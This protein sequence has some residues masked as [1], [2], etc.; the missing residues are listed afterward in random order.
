MNIQQLSD[1]DLFEI[2]DRLP[3]KEFLAFAKSSLRIQSAASIYF[4]RLSPNY[5]ITLKLHPFTIIRVYSIPIWQ[6]KLIDCFGSS[7]Q[8]E[9]DQDPDTI[10]MEW[11]YRRLEYGHMDRSAEIVNLVYDPVV[12]MRYYRTRRLFK[13]KANFWWDYDYCLYVAGLYH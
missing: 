4:Q 10:N 11:I 7:I 3:T 2:F 8:Y 12:M 5:T 6:I 1:E 9:L 13:L